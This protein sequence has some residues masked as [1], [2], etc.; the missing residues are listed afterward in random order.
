MFIQDTQ[1]GPLCLAILSVTM[2][3]LISPDAEM[4][5]DLK[6]QSLPCKELHLL[7]S[8]KAELLSC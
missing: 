1:L 4:E 5:M 6:G 8:I 3:Y 2:L 7:Q